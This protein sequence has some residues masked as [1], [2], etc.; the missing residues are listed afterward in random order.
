[1]TDADVDGSHIRTLLLTFFYRQMPELVERGHIYIAQPPLYKVKQGKE[2]TY[3]KDD[4]ELKQHLLKVALKGA[5]LVPGAGR[6]PLAAETLRERR[7]R[8]PARRGGDRAAR[9]ARRARGAV[10]AARRAR[11]STSSSEAAAAASAA[12][13]AGGDRRSRRARRGAL[14]SGD[15]DA[16]PR[17]RRARTTARRTSTAIDADLIAS[18]ATTRRSARRPTVLQGLIRPGATVRRGEQAAGG[19]VVQGGARLAARRGARAASRCSAT[20]AWAR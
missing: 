14:R 17:H 15:R 1:M 18:A 19:A 9:A 2:E 10:R 13:A 8:V 16:P 5:E 7:A 3:L 20:R 12:R 6:P 4:H 11:A